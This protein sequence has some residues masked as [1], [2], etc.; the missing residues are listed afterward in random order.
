MLLGEGE[1]TRWLDA[2]GL[3]HVRMTRSG[4]LSGTLA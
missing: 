4:Q 1:G 3:P 2:L